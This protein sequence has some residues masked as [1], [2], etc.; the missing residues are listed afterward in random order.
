[1][2]HRKKPDEVFGIS[3]DYRKISY[4][5]RGEIDKVLQTY[6][7]EMSILHSAENLNVESHGFDKKIFQAHWSFSADLA[8]RYQIYM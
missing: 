1:M 7:A 3:S 8:R 2:F 5:D 6:L 4:V